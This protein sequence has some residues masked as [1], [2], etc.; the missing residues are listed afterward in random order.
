MLKK[1]KA[2]IDTVNADCYAQSVSQSVS[3]F[4]VFSY[5]ALTQSFVNIFLQQKSVLHPPFTVRV[6]HT[7]LLYGGVACK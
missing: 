1:S 5:H 4:H 6:K 2:C 3:Q 7:L